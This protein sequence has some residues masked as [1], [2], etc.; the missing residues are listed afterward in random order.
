MSNVVGGGAPAGYGGPSSYGGSG[1][2]YDNYGGSKYGESKKKSHETANTYNYGNTV[3]HFGDYG[4]NRSAIDKYRDPKNEK[5][6]TTGGYT[7]DTKKEEKRPEIQVET[8]K[9]FEKAAGKL[10]KPG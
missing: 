3:G 1:S 9:P 4:V 5:P 8:K 2:G 6:S 7:A 10:S